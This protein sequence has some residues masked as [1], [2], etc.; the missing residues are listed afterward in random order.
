MMT[1]LAF[2]N[3]MILASF[4]VQRRNSCRFSAQFDESLN[5]SRCKVTEISQAFS[6]LPSQAGDK[7][8][9]LCK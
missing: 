2:L 3:G 8:H 7:K 5:E 4:V 1:H 6:G 9:N